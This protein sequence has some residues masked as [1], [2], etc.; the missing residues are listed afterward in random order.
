MNSSADVKWRIWHLSNWEGM[1]KDQIDLERPLLY[2]GG[3]II[4]PYGH[5]WVI[6]GYNEDDEFHCNWGWGGTYDD[7]YSLGNFNNQNGSFNEIESAIFNLFP[8]QVSGVAIPQLTEQ[9]FTY[10]SNGYTLNVP[11]AFGATSYDWITDHGTISGSGPSVT[12]YSTETANVQVKAYNDLCEI[13]SSYD[14]TTIT[15]NYG[16]IS[17]SSSVCSSGTEYTAINLPPGAT[18]TWSCSENITRNSA[19]GSNPCTFQPNTEG[20]YGTINATI[21]YNGNQY[22]LEQKYVWVGSN[23]SDPISIV[24][25]GENYEFVEH[26]NDM[27]ELCPNTIYRLQAFSSSEVYGWD[28]RIPWNWE[29]LSDENSPEILIQTG[30]NIYWEDEVVVDV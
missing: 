21:S 11:E 6:D 26:T 13:Y 3:H 10:S 5:S 12:L 23:L 14:S 27:W 18:I 19:Q 29:L 20:N 16:P 7:F 17:G 25:K 4:P 24:I 8:N 2:S 22:Y 9:Y 1:L 15:I 28:W 30:D